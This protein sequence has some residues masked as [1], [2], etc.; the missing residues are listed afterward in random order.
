MR[1]LIDYRPALRERTGAGEFVH[2][3]AAALARHA[4]LKIDVT[5]FTSS[6]K[7]RLRPSARRELG[8]AEAVDV[9][10][11]VR[12]LN[13]GWHRLGWPPIE[14][15]ARRRFDVVH[16][17]HPLAIPSTRAAQVITIHDL[18]FLDFPSHTEAEI[19]RDYPGLVRR[20]AERADM[21]IVPSHHT[22]RLIRQRLGISHDRI[23]LCRPG[24]PAWADRIASAREPR[25][26][27]F[28][29][30]LEP[31]KN[32]GVLL[33]AYTRLLDAGRPVPDL[34][35]GGK[36][37][38]AARGWLDRLTRPP[39]AGHVRHL[40]YVETDQ[41]LELYRRARLLVLPSL[42][43]G[44][45]LPV[46]EAMACG[47]PVVVSTRGSLPEVAGSAGLLIDPED[48]DGWAGAIQRMLED[49]PFA[50][51]SA[52]SGRLRVREM[53]W[54]HAAEALKQAYEHALV[55]RQAR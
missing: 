44:F 15:V 55:A 54:D 50:A 22:G 34:V 14:L 16:A 47:V 21:I 26:I 25:D 19:R 27:V 38:A 17:A 18:H 36:A 51:A 12:M 8:P 52:A 5:V 39:L 45:G 11:P 49:D 53:T 46:L 3:I 42:D 10:I 2:Q 30:T 20:H 43:E 28:L 13:L 6:W 23:A 31:R 41:R 4:A 35:L 48:V 32:I 29:G 37:T 1:V 7:D 33:D 24:A 9:R 40:G